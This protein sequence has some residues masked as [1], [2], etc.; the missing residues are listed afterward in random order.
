MGGT[1]AMG[2]YLLPYLT[3][4]NYDVYVTSRSNQESNLKNL[5]YLQGNAK[6]LNWLKSQMG[7]GKFDAIF[8][9]MMYNVSEF[10]ERYR[11]LLDM[12]NQYFYISSYRAYGEQ[13]GELSEE[14]T[15]LKSDM[16]DEHL[17][18]QK[19]GYGVG[20]GIQENLLRQSGRNNWTIIRP[21]MTF[22]KRRI[23]FFSGDNFD[24]IR[25]TRGVKSAIPAE[26]LDYH[27]GITY[28]KDVAKF[29]LNFI[30]KEKAFGEAFH[31][32]VDV[33]SWRE[34]SEIYHDV[35]DLDIVTVPE[36]SYRDAIG[37]TKG[38]YE[39]RIMERKFKRDKSLAVAELSVD[40]FY[41][42]KAGLIEAW[43][44][45]D[46]ET[47]GKMI[48]W[49]GFQAKMDVLVGENTDLSKVDPSLRVQFNAIRENYRDRVLVS[50]DGFN[51]KVINQYWEKEQLTDGVL[52]SR[53]S[54]QTS[55][56]MDN[57]WLNFEIPQNLTKM[58]AADK[59]QLTMVFETE[60]DF[61]FTP[62]LHHYGVGNQVL[63]RK[64]LS[65]GVT[66]VSWL[67]TPSRTDFT[68]VAIT[69]TD[70]SEN[71]MAKLLSLTL[72]LPNRNP[73][74]YGKYT[75]GRI[76]IVNSPRHEPKILTVGK[77]TSIAPDVSL[78]I[79]THGIDRVS[80]YTWFAGKAL[81]KDVSWQSNIVDEFDSFLGETIIGNDVWI[82]KDV[83]IM[84]GVT[85]G[86]GAIIGT[87]AVITKDVPP[88]AVVAGVPAKIL[89]YRFDEEAI[90]AFLRIKWW[91]WSEELIEKRFSDVSGADIA[92]FVR[93]YDVK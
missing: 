67:F 45:T 31:P 82:G 93:K 7:D 89:K 85:I 88:F 32:V 75:Y 66:E 37:E 25:A 72:S 70:F 64:R 11:A 47:F 92:D 71:K 44:E 19:D 41:G 60:D 77:F 15:R 22:S 27:N 78:M 29:L 80:T 2:M 33:L 42:T 48:S 28:G 3:E 81:S 18:Y 58:L 57:R 83:N 24:I 53:T 59:I 43:H 16:L 1:G 34:L 35:F 62:F 23:Q 76:K 10:T 55:G 40:D 69:A 73:V 36:S 17:E 9:F 84:G 61:E 38:L 5:T 79:R 30:G 65:K 14:N 74:E 20:K 51:V 12:T 26:F 4:S 63:N 8:D 21:T 6:D 13:T 91:N 86:D 52:L 68:D 49:E 50:I 39:D 87:G 90:A 46:L 56:Q 54:R